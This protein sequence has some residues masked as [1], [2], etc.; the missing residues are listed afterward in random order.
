MA[1]ASKTITRFDSGLS[2][3]SKGAGA[4]FNKNLDIYSDANSA[5]LNPALVKVSGSTVTDFVKCIAEGVPYDTNKY[6]LGDTGIIYKETSGGSWSTFHT[7]TTGLNSTDIVSMTPGGQGLCVYNNSLY[8]ASD[9]SIGRYWPLTNGSP[10]SSDDY[11]EAFIG[12]IDQHNTSATGNTYAIPSSITEN[13]A[14]T[15][16]FTPTQEPYASISLYITAKSSADLTV[17]VHDSLNNV[18]GTATLT[19]ASINDTNVNFWVFSTPLRLTLGVTYHFHVTKSGGSPT[20]KTTTVNDLSTCY[21]SGFFCLVK[22]ANYHPLITHTNGVNATMLIGNGNYIGEWDE[23]SGTYNPN[24]IVLDSGYSVRSFLKENEFVVAECWKGT[25]IDG[26]E[27]GMLYYWDGIST[28]FNYAKPVTSGLPNA[29]VNFKNRILSVLGS[30]A[31][32]TLGTEPFLFIQNIPKLARGKKI[33]VLPGAIDVWQNKAVIGI[34]ANTD[35]GT[36]IVQGVYEYGS[37]SDRDGSEILNLGYTIST[38]DTQGTTMKI[39]AVKAFGKDLYV[40]WKSQS[41]TYGVDKASKTGNAASSASWESGI[42]D[43]VKPGKPAPQK[44]KEAKRLVITF[45]TLASGCTVTPKYRI[46]RSTSWVT[47]NFQGGIAGTTSAY[48]D[49]N[50]RYKEI[51]VGWD[52]TSTGANI[53]ITSIY[54]EWDPLENE[55]GDSQ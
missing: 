32:I 9:V 52:E 13:A 16:S 27:Q 19:N 17:T 37:A 24:K 43:E 29:S 15:L 30:R 34:G 25:S 41:S 5:S 36:G 39:G 33:E 49:I 51:E 31:T 7:M 18:I 53:V 45:E 2:S 21:Y 55:R 47:T 22:D 42:F 26:S 28:Y 38:G 14:N 44:E 35:D 46:N 40:S 1:N 12:N 4:N 54:Y 8:A 50:L 6:F 11:F 48:I 23:G 20:L 3:S 10:I